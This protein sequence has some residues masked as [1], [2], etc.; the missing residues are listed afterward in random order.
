MTGAEAKSEAGG[1]HYWTSRDGL[2]LHYRDY[3]GRS[4]RPPIICLHGLTRNGRDFA[5]LAARLVGEWR[6][7]VPDFRGRGG[8]DYDPAP[9]HYAPPTYAGDVIQLMGLLQVEAAV[10]IGTSLGGLVT[11]AIATVAPRMIA[12]TVLNDVGPEL[13]AAGLERIRGYVGQFARFSD[14]AEAA[15]HLAERNREIHP[16]YTLDDWERMARRICRQIEGSIRF[17]Y[18]MAIAD[19]V[20]APATGPAV[21]AWPF[22]RALSHAPLL[23]L[24]GELSD[25]LS[26]KTALAMGADHPDSEL[27]CVDDV[28]HAPDLQE[29]EAIAGIERLL[30]KV[31]HKP[32][33]VNN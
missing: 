16:H 11:M 27:I 1:V 29:P 23:I 7:I 33:E 32:P 5:E 31:A 26:A 4:D 28:G 25:L 10:F 17:D 18:D 9:E 14:W 20:L 8:S 13:E 2:R 24:R 3:P 6:V 12:G 19:N 22:F 15:G 30:A 21:D